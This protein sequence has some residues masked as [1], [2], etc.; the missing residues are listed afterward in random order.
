MIPLLFTSPLP[1]LIN[2]LPAKFAELGQTGVEVR[3][4]TPA[5]RP[6]KFVLLLGDGGPRT[7]EVH[8]LYRVRAQVWATFANGATDWDTVNTLAA[9]LQLLLERFAKESPLVATVTDSTGPDTVQDPAGV[10]Y[11]FLTVEYQLRGVPA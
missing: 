10:E 7:R 4:L 3:R 2:T 6:R 8:R 9:Q 11:R 1:A 5:T